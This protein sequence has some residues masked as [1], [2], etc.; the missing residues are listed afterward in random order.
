MSVQEFI[1]SCALGEEFKVE[2]LMKL[3]GFNP[4]CADVKVLFGRDY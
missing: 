2:D 4:N 1:N 3:K